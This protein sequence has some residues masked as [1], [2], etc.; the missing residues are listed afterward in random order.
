MARA[1]VFE[2]DRN[3][4]SIDQVDNPITVGELRA[5]LED[6]ADDTLFILSHDRGY[7]YGSVDIMTD[8][9]TYEEDEDGEWVATDW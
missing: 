2:A 1:L 4:Y 8:V 5:F 6:F 3:G 9:T 7:T